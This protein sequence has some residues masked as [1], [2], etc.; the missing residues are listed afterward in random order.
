VQGTKI[1]AIVLIAVGILAL[2]YGGFSYTHDTHQAS[3]G[4]IDIAVR[5]NRTFD[6]PIWAGLGIIILGGALLLAGNRKGQ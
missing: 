6:V 3:I 4:P 1:A 5:D 2:A